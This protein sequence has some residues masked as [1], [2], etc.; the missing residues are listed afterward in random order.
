MAQPC[1]L[2]TPSASPG[3]EQR[4]RPAGLE[5]W[6]LLFSPPLGERA[7]CVLHSLPHR[8]RVLTRICELAAGAVA[9]VPSTGTRL[10]E[11]AAAAADEGAQKLGIGLCR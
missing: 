2:A 5:P 1:L 7:A 9:V 8:V 6:P 3:R 10:Q 11:E 4:A